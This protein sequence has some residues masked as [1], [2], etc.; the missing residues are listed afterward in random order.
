MSDNIPT[1]A[2]SATPPKKQTKKLK[3]DKTKL[4][5]PPPDPTR[6]KDKE[7]DVFEYL[8]TLIPNY[9]RS[10]S[11]FAPVVATEEA[12]DQLEKLY[13]L[14]EQMLELREQNAKLH[15]RIRDLE[16]LNNLE[17][18]QKQLELSGAEKDCPELDRDTAFAETILESILADSSRKDNKQKLATP[19]RLRPS[20]LRKQ[21]NRSGSGSTDKQ[22]TLDASTTV[23]EDESSGDHDKSAKVSKWTKVKAAFRWEKASTTVG[24]NKSQDSGIHVPVNVEIARY[25]RVPSTSDDTGHSPADSGAAGISTPGS[26]STTSST[27]DFHRAEL[28]TP[29]EDL[30]SSED[31]HSQ[32][33]YIPHSKEDHSSAKTHLRIHRT[34]WEKVKGIIPGRNSFKKKHRLS[35]ASD[36]I[37]I[38]VE[39]CSD[40]EVFEDDPKSKFIQFLPRSESSKEVPQEVIERYQSA[41]AENLDKDI[42][43]WAMVKKA[44]LI[45]EHRHMSCPASPKESTLE[46]EI[47]RDYRKLQKKLSLEFQEKLSEWERLKQSSPAGSNPSSSCGFVEEN[48]DPNFLK[49][50]EEWQK[51]KSHQ[52][53]TKT[54]MPSEFDLP[55]E[56][57]KKLQ[58][59]EKIKKSS[60]KEASG[61]KKK[62]GEVGRWKSLSGHR[63][64]T[65][66]AFEY[67]PL[68]ED[69]RKKLDEWKQIKA[70]G[71]ASNL[72][73]AS[74]KQ[75]EKSPSP[76]L[77]RKDSSPKHSKKQK[78]QDKDIYWVEKELNKIEKEK[79][80][81][82]RE[83]QKFLEREERLSKLRK[84]VIGG[85]KKEVLIH[86]PSGFYRFEGIS[87]KFTQK[88]YEWEK[89]KGIAPEASTFALL[90]SSYT[91]ENKPVTKRH[92]TSNTPPITRS[93]SADSIAISAL[94]LTCPLMTH[95]PSS[96]SLNDVEELEKECLANSKSSSMQYLIGSEEAL[97]MDE[98]EAVL[99]EVEDYEE[100]TAAPLHT[101]V[102]KHQLPIYQRQEGK[103]LCEGETI[104]APKIR[105][106]ESTRAQ[107]NYNLIED[108]I[109]VLK[110]LA[111]NEVEV[112]NL[113]QGGAKYQQ[114]SEIVPK[115]EMIYEDQ[116]QLSVNLTKKLQSLQ[117]AN[118]SV[119]LAILREEENCQ[120]N[121]TETLEAVQD[122]SNEIIQM[123]EQMD[124]HFNTR[125]PQ[126]FSS[127]YKNYLLVFENIRDIRTKI[128]DLRRHLSYVCAATDS[129][130]PRK[131]SGKKKTLVQKTI[132]NES[133][134]SRCDT[135]DNSRRG[136]QKD[137]KRYIKSEN[138]SSSNSHS[139]GA[140]KK[141]IKYRQKVMQNRSLP[142][143]DDEEEDEAAEQRKNNRQ[144]KKLTRARTISEVYPGVEPETPG[145]LPQKIIVPTETNYVVV[146]EE[147][148][149]PPESPLTVFVKTTRKLFTPI[150]ET[151]L[152]DTGKS[153]TNESPSIVIETTIPFT[154]DAESKK[155]QEESPNSEDKNANTTPEENVSVKSLPPLPASPVPQKKVLKDI[156]PSIRL[157]LAKYNQKITEQESPSAKSGNSSGSNS[158]I[159]WRSPAAERRVKAQTE[160]YQEELIRMSPLLGERREVQK[161]AS[162]SYLS[163][164]T[165][166]VTV[167]LR[168][169]SVQ[170]NLLC[171]PSTTCTSGITEEE[172]PGQPP[173]RPDRKTLTLDITPNLPDISNR[174]S[175]EIR[176]KKLQ[177]AKEEFLRSTPVSA[178]AHINEEIIKF[179]TRNRLSQISVD[180]E[181]SYDS[182]L[183]GAL[184]KSASVGMINVD[185]DTYRQIDPELH[186]GGYVSL[187]RSTSNHKGNKFGFASIASKF[188]KV[189]MRKGKER[190]DRN[191]EGMNAVSALCRHS[192]VVDITKTNLEDGHAV[193]GEG[194]G[195]PPAPSAHNSATSNNNQHSRRGGSPSS[196]TNT[197][198]SSTSWLKKSLFKK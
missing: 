168:R 106:S 150:A 11:T 54:Q 109:N 185:P 149:L 14:M 153:S 34:P 144:H 141:R 197:T 102:E 93:M 158:P 89:A 48:K 91:P 21:R 163:S 82:E 56:F 112:K 98:P 138:T 183:P 71:G 115:L 40:E 157:M 174:H 179:P 119:I 126:N 128:L 86:T 29:C 187:P 52:T 2:N 17:K 20:I 59:W 9:T 129:T 160:K 87:R 8:E 159:A 176:L 96:L 43:R 177:K 18:M 67:P 195:L 104:A 198:K 62:L 53:S 16:H 136:S 145:F 84:S 35:A 155:S 69:F 1:D 181:S 190:G 101:Y 81:L 182:T 77:I 170:E 78:E 130:A 169:E 72:L 31:E 166:Q 147:P 123:A 134:S 103:A 111:E 194:S 60:G 105:K 191:K 178:P 80:R 116:K 196:S 42:S 46:D 33:S 184:I 12:F 32:H 95:Q 108:I 142:D 100:E 90:S 135:S 171:N 148:K 140:V 92:S 6:S 73:Q 152:A 121:I 120:M 5:T 55:P 45:S 23:Q 151:N 139:Q 65:S 41:L 113:S 58:E 75:K 110:Q 193:E 137:E 24:D 146:Q 122:V 189:K 50:M 132:S 188:R 85:N 172:T 64:E 127:T 25:L 114:T 154:K 124:Q 180:S 47:Q 36:D 131:L 30:R 61:V 37:Q 143:T 173:R 38:D 118:T 156:S 162:V 79:Q 70:A 39:P 164:G 26:L 133:K 66:T 49:K 63:S 10:T 94:N 15:R 192:L 107:V 51:M 57:K 99:V 76:K 88:L 167:P 125:S 117:E 175:P 97:D 27:E 74:T 4:P 83:R 3:Y 13:K 186:G 161:S 22:V 28:R 7:R 165:K 44:F 19:T 68:S